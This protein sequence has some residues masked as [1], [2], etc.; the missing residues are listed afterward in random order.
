MFISPGERSSNVEWHFFSYQCSPDAHP[1]R[2]CK[3]G[4]QST[5]GLKSRLKISLPESFKAIQIELGAE[6]IFTEAIVSKPQGD[7]VAES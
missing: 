7:E 3:S 2:V 6:A 4:P 5:S 1:T